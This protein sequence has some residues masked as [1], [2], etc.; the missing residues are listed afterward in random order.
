MFSSSI[1]FTVLVPIFLWFE[2]LLKDQDLSIAS[3]PCRLS[4]VSRLKSTEHISAES[5]PVACSSSIIVLH[6]IV[7][8][9]RHVMHFK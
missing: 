3:K 2:A 6:C 7:Q 4:G 5:T 9:D 8:Y 1:F